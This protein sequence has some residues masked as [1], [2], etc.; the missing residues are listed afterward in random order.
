MLKHENHH[1]WS[2][3][4]KHTLLVTD[5]KPISTQIPYYTTVIKL[6]RYYNMIKSISFAIDNV[7]SIMWSSY[8]LLIAAMLLDGFILMESF[9]IQVGISIGI[10]LRVVFPHIMSN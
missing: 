10:K 9:V 8:D 4:L 1:S 3:N 7:E 5:V 6:S 2:S